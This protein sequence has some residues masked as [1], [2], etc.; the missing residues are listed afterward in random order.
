MQ[1]I[2]HITSVIEAILFATGDSVPIK[3][4][5]TCLELDEKTTKN[6]ILSMIDDYSKEKRGINIIKIEDNVQMCTNLEYFPYIK[7]M[8]KTQKRKKLSQ[9][10][11]ETLAIIAY[12]QPI[13]KAEVEAIRGVNSE[14]SINSL[15]KHGLIEE[16]GRLDTIGKPIIFGT[17]KEFL[18][19]FGFSSLENM[20]KIKNYS[21][22]KIE[23][24]NELQNF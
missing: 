20:P 24:E 3:T 4:I 21:E 19:Y 5:A 10:L 8:I 11:L 6:I 16:K 22:L 23:V 7:K 1:N 13:T 2:G 12:R 18:K 15:L 9:T 14:H 17:T